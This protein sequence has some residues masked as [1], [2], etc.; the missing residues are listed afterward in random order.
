MALR[1]GTSLNS[2]GTGLQDSKSSAAIVY[3]VDNGAKVIN[4]SWGSDRLSFVIRDV[5]IYADVQGVLLIAAAGNDMKGSVIYP[6]GYRQVLA[7]ASGNQDDERFYQSNFGAGVDIVAP[8]NEIL[9]TQIQ[10]TYRL[11]SGTS[12]ASPHVVGVA[13]LMMSKPVSYTH[14][15]AHET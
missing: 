9:S 7:V 3:A 1:A 10:D 14:L 4:M 6:A 5:L 2:G 11:L 8:G 13:A 12:M 15:R